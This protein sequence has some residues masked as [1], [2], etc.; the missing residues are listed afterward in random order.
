MIT[1]K[2]NTIRRVIKLNPLTTKLMAAQMNSREPRN[3]SRI[4]INEDAEISYW[5][6]KFDCSRDELEDAVEQVGYSPRL[7]EKFFGAR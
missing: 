4:N 7:V 5:C 3:L 2:Q 1:A 6:N